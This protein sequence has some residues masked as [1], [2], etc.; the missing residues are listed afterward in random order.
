MKV[1]HDFGIFWRYIFRLF[2]RPLP[3]ELSVEVVDPL[4]GRKALDI[5]KS[6]ADAVDIFRD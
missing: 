3:T 1:S 4:L 6:R 2:S 5:M